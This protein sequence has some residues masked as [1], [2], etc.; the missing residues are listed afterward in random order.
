MIAATG[1]GIDLGYDDLGE[2]SAPAAVFIGGLA[3]QRTVWPDTLCD[4]LAG[5][6]RR[7]IRFDNR[8]M[9]ESTW[10]ESPSGDALAK[11]VQQPLSATSVL[12]YTID[13]MA[14]DV[15]GLLDALQ[16]ERAH[17]VGMSLGGRIAQA[18]AARWPTRTASLVSMMSTTGNPVLPPPR[19]EA[20]A[21]LMTPP[22]DPFDVESVSQLAIMQQRVIGSP[23]YPMP[24]SYVR[25]VVA[26]NFRRGN[27]PEGALRQW[28]ASVGAGDRRQ[29]LRR[30]AAPTLVLHGKDDPLVLPA[31]GEDTAAN[32]CGAKLHILD[33]WGHNIPPA[34]GPLLAGE[35]T[36]FWT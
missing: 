5:R 33:G 26:L 22:Q 21:A 3:T 36:A 23:R 25:E 1:H 19:P 10:W 9:G 30:I 29:S 15:V 11:L 13:D 8:D 2:R 34:I 27:N 16:I 18:V 35:L 17:I 7:V 6:G 32:I 20:L 12:P 14:Q 24:D 28:A 31:A 4:A